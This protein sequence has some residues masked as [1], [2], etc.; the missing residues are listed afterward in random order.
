MHRFF[1]WI[2]LFVNELQQ[3]HEPAANASKDA[4]NDLSCGRREF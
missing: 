2:A 1:S 4:S 3:Q